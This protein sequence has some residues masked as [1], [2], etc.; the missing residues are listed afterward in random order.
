VVHTRS[1]ESELNSG[2]EILRDHH[3]HVVHRHLLRPM[4]VQERDIHRHS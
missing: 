1:L 3:A 2:E 4:T